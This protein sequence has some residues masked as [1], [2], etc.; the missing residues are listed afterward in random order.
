[1]KLTCLGTGSSGNCY[2]LEDG[3][4]TLVIEAGIHFREVKRAL[5]FN[6]SRIVGVVVSHSHGDHAKYAGAYEKAGIPV[7]K[8]YEMGGASR[9]P[10]RY[11]RFLVECLPLTDMQGRFMH[12]NP[13]GTEC[14]CY[15]FYIT[16]PGMGSL[17]YATDTELVKW[18]FQGVN[19]VLVEANYSASLIDQGAANRSHVLTGHMELQTTLGFLRANDSPELRNVILCHL[20]GSNADPGMFQREAQKAVECPVH[21]AERGLAV[22]VSLEPF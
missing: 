7:F 14:P 16:H 13:D 10:R 2:L 22:D 21:V 18:R 20:S 12:S 19:H 17:F 1:M 4:E 11:G 3:T 15:G 8:P 5:N 9:S 6:V